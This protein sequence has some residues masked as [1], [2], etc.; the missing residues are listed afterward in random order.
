VLL[1]TRCLVCGVVSILY[2]SVLLVRV[3]VLG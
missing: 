2:K 1:Y 3:C